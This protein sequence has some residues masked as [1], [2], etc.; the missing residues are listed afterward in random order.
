VLVEPQLLGHQDH[1]SRQDLV[2]D[3]DGETGEAQLLVNDEWGLHIFWA[4]PF[5]GEWRGEM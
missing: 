2:G 3:D 4:S 1:S 5:R